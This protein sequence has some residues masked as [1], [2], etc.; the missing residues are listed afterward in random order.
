MNLQE[1]YESVFELAEEAKN[2][3]ILATLNITLAK[4]DFENANKR[5]YPKKV[6]KKATEDFNN[7]IKKQ[8]LSG[9]LANLDHAQGAYPELSKG[10]HL[11]TKLWMDGDLM[12]GTAKIL[13]T[14]KGRDVMV[15]LKSGVKPGISIKGVGNIGKDGTIKDDGSYKLMSADIVNKASFG[16]ITKIT[17]AELF[18]SVNNM[19]KEK[20]EKFDVSIEE[21]N[22]I[23]NK[24]IKHEFE[25]GFPDANFLEPNTQK[26]LERY[27]DEHWLMYSEIIEKELK[28]LT[29]EKSPLEKKTEKAK[30]EI[31]PDEERAY[32][33]AIC[34]GY[35]GTFEVF[36]K[37]VL[38]A[39][40]EK[41]NN[42]GMEFDE[43]RKSGGIKNFEAFKK[44]KGE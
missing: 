41:E 23:V 4:A 21:F 36:K 43:Y 26:A 32:N 11:I 14:S 35:N 37:E 12:R 13:N 18:E 28:P 15:I 30:G 7:E 34:S 38:P 25:I 2:P 20:E 40:S 5:T 42:L 31:Y 29:V 22:D 9:I 1:I 19:I 27:I 33:E 39:L 8:D 44:M 10:S 3:N 16:D 24:M 6:L 17:S